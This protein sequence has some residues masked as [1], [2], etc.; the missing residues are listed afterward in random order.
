MSWAAEAV[1][2]AAA[3]ARL[4]RVQNGLIASLGVIVGATWSCSNSHCRLGLQTEVRTATLTVLV[5]IALTTFGNAF[6]D[7]RDVEIDR[8]AHPA[9]PLPS[10]AMTPD[11]AV[12]LFAAAA[13]VAVALSLAVTPWMAAASAGVL[14]AMAA[15]SLWLKRT[16]IAGNLCVA[17]LASLPFVYGAWATGAP[18]A[19]L[20]LF[21]LAVPLHLAREIAKDIDDIAGDRTH[22]ATLPVAFGPRVARAAFA[23]A[24]VIFIGVLAIIVARR[25]LLGA[26]VV[27]ALLACGAGA[28]CVA[29]GRPGGARLLKAAMVLA[30]VPFLVIHT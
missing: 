10:G 27:P 6:N 30:M 25:P 14:L 17:A 7:W 28:R 15:Y 29:I 5:A 19:A 26:L 9:R 4:A 8:V 24:L 3:I 22:R 21:A 23:T 13:I 16:G 20:P 2:R 11:A 18:G 1:A 12:T